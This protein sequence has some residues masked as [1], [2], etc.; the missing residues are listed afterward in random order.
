M[1][2]FSF[3]PLL[4]GPDYNSLFQSGGLSQLVNVNGRHGECVVLP[5]A[6]AITILANVNPSSDS[7]SSSHKCTIP[8]SSLASCR[9]KRR[10]R[11]VYIPPEG[12]FIS[13]S[14]RLYAVPIISQKLQCPNASLIHY[15]ERLEHICSTVGA[16]HIH[17]DELDLFYHILS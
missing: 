2:F 16:C 14:T 15:L 11:S 1:D 3:L 4:A 9:G 6:S 8:A 10:R 12:S 5:P 7:L 13:N 17:C